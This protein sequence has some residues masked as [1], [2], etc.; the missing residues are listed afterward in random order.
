MASYRFRSKGEINAQNSADEYPKQALQRTR[1]DYMTN[2]KR[3]QNSDS[4]RFVITKHTKRSAPSWVGRMV[5]P[6][7]WGL[8]VNGSAPQGDHATLKKPLERGMMRCCSSCESLRTAMSCSQQTVCA[9]QLATPSR[10]RGVP[11]RSFDRLSVVFLMDT[12]SMR[13]TRCRYVHVNPTFCELSCT[14]MPSS[15]NNDCAA[16]LLAET[17]DWQ[18]CRDWSDGQ[19]VAAELPLTRT[20]SA[21]VA[22]SFR[23][24]VRWGIRGASS[25]ID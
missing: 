20:A 24:M 2:L 11:E 10:G 9:L 25:W 19:G 5:D 6:H 16:W 17:T 3:T 15:P 12:M 1:L 4:I 8:Q 14:T 22:V 18:H 7:A 21:M 13:W 23:N